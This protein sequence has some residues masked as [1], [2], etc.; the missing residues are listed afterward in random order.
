MGL[1]ESKEAFEKDEIQQTPKVN[2]EIGISSMWDPRSPSTLFERTPIK[3]KQENYIGCVESDPRSPTCDVLRTPINTEDGHITEKNR[4]VY[5]Q[6][7]MQ[8]EKL[9]IHDGG[10]HNVTAS[11]ENLHSDNEVY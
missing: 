8:L 5:S 10:L 1:S 9:Q 6:L 4:N 3:K 7:R 11:T 2:K